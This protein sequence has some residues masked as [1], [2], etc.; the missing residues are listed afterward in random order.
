MRAFGP[1]LPPKCVVFGPV[2]VETRRKLSWFLCMWILNAQRTAAGLHRH[3][4]SQLSSFLFKL[5]CGRRDKALPC[6]DD[7]RHQTISKWTQQ[8]SNWLLILRLWAYESLYHS[9]KPL[10]INLEL[11][12]SSSCRVIDLWCVVTSRSTHHPSHRV[13]LNDLPAWTW[14]SHHLTSY[15][16]FYWYTNGKRAPC[17][18]NCP[19]LSVILVMSALIANSL[20][21]S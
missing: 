19:E 9:S 13:S 3:H 4:S 18:E 11:D 10:A 14:T 17:W 5:L 2:V 16:N 15:F 6:L 12:V 7:A 8:L 20:R 21:N 1:H